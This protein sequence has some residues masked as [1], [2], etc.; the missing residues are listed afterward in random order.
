MTRRAKNDQVL[1]RVGLAPVGKR[2]AIV[3]L[4]ASG[5]AAALASN[6]GSGERMPACSLPP[7]RPVDRA[8]RFS[9]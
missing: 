6:P 4:E 8:M 7:P 9:H 2:H 1:E 3:N 5:G